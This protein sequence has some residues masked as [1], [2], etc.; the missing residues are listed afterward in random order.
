MLKNLWVIIMAL[1]EIFANALLNTVSWIIILWIGAYVVL[2]MI[3]KFPLDNLEDENVK[4]KSKSN[5]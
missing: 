5:K 3:K 4:S 2:K 1:T